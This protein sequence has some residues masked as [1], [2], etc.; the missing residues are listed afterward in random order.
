MTIGTR[1]PDQLDRYSAPF[2]QAVIIWTVEFVQL[3]MASTQGGGFQGKGYQGGR[4]KQGSG[5]DDAGQD[6]Q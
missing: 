3:K 4:G 6:N 2:S 5:W 1:T